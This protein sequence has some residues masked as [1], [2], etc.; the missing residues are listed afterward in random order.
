MIRAVTPDNA[1][2]LANMSGL[3]TTIVPTGYFV[4]F[5]LDSAGRS[6]NKALQDIRVR[7]AIWQ[8]IDRDSIIKHIVPGGDKGIAHTMKGLCFD[9]N[10]DCKVTVPPPPYDLAAAKKLLAE[11]GYSNG[12]DLEYDCYTPIKYIC[13][14]VAGELRKANIRAK[15]FSSTIAVYRQHQSAGEQQAF[16]VFYPTPVLPD[17]GSIFGVF[18]Q[19]ERDYSRDPMLTQW[20]AEAAK[21]LDPAKRTAILEKALNRANDQVYTMALF[22]YPTIYAHTKDLKI[23]KDPLVAGDTYINDYAWK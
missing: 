23:N 16:S 20:Q 9:Y 17:T 5:G 4:F 15:I 11:A 2:E 7:K 1:K 8:A 22:S 13:E 18:F 14:A 10:I 3:T 21:E 12:L 19:G 6:K